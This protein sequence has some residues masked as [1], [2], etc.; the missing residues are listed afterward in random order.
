MTLI[1]IILA[2]AADS[3]GRRKEG[4]DVAGMTL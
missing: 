1:D 2:N 4:N 3:F